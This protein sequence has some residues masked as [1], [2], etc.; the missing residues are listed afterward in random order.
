MGT[1]NLIVARSRNNVIGKGGKI[2]WHL[3]GE[4][5][6]FTELTTGNVVIMG[7]KTYEEIGHP[8]PNRLNV[9]VS[10]TKSFG[11]RIDSGEFT[12]VLDA[13][14][15]QEALDLVGD[16]TNVDVYIAG[17]HRLYK[18]AL[19]M[20]IVDRMYITEIDMDVEPDS[21][22]V[23]FPEFDKT[24]FK[25]LTGETVEDEIPYTRTV[26]YRFRKTKTL[27]IPKTEAELIEKLSKTKPRTPYECFTGTLTH[28]V[29]FGNSIS[30]EIKL[31]G[32]DYR[33]D[34]DNLPW[35]EAVLFENDHDICCAGP[36][37]SYFGIRRLTY[38]GFT[39][40]VNVT[41]EKENAT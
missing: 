16:L 32:G 31:C 13:T 11:C 8:L 5:T 22:T 20:N 2:P 6:Q 10:R 21:T 18:E 7:R 35:A 37:T 38:N 9:V 1:I 27:V 3:K 4:Q 41:K 14:S 33:K 19:A 15:L 29:T 17:G 23:F 28:T 36:S 26:Y 34:C 25:K 30:I 24:V 39:Y 12:T 40:I